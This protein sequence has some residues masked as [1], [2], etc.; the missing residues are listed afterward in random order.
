[1]TRSAC[2]HPLTRPPAGDP[3]VLPGGH[4]LVGHVGVEVEVEHVGEVEFAAG[5]G[6]RRLGGLAPV[7][8][9][10]AVPARAGEEVAVVRVELPGEVPVPALVQRAERPGLVFAFAAFE[11]GDALYARLPQLEQSHRPGVDCGNSSVR[12][13][14][15]VG[16]NR[17]AEM[18][19]KGCNN[20]TYDLIRCSKGSEVV[21]TT[22]SAGDPGTSSTTRTVDAARG[23]GA[24]CEPT[25]R[26]GV[27]HGDQEAQLSRRLGEVEQV[28]DR[29][30][31]RGLRHE[32]RRPRVLL[33]VDHDDLRI[34][35]A[36]S[37]GSY[38]VGRGEGA[39]RRGEAVA[40]R[41][42]ARQA[43]EGVKVP[44]KRVHTH[45]SAGE[46][47]CGDGVEG[48]A[49][50]DDAAAGDAT[51]VAVARGDQ[52][53]H[54]GQRLGQRLGE[55][56]DGL[57]LALQLVGLQPHQ[58]RA[59]PR[60]LGAPKIAGLE[61]GHVLGRAALGNDAQ[62]LLV[63][64]AGVD[65]R[66]VSGRAGHSSTH[67]GVDHLV[68]P[69]LE[70]ALAQ[71]RQQLLALHL[72]AQGREPLQVVV[73]LLR[74]QR[75]VHALG[76][77]EQLRLQRGQLLPVR[78]EDGLGVLALLVGGEREAADALGNAFLAHDDHALQQARGGHVRP[79]ADLNGVGD[80]VDRLAV[81]GHADDPDGLGVDVGEVG[82]DARDLD[83]LLEGQLPDLHLPVG[84]DDLLQP[85]LDAL[86]RLVAQRLGSSDIELELLG[87]QLGPALV[88]VLVVD[89]AEHEVQQVGAGVVAGDLHAAFVV[90]AGLQGGAGARARFRL[91]GVDAEVE[92]H[93]A[94][95]QHLQDIQRAQSPLVPDLA[96]GLGV[97]GGAVQ[98]HDKD[99]PLGEGLV[100]PG[101]GPHGEH[102]DVVLEVRAVAVFDAVAHF[103]RHQLREV[104]GEPEGA[105]EEEGVGAADHQRR[106]AAGCRLQ[107]GHRL[108]KAVAALVQ[109]LQKQHLLVVDRL[110][111]LVVLVLDLGEGEAERGDHAVYQLGQERPRGAQVLP[112]VAH[113]AAQ[114]AAKHVAAPV[115]GGLHA[116]RDGH[117]EAP[118]VV[119]HYAVR[120]VHNRVRS[121]VGRQLRHHLVDVREY[122]G[123]QVAGVVAVARLEHG[124]HA[125]QAHAG[126]DA[127]LGEQLNAA[128]APAVVL[129]EDQ[130]PELH[131]HGVV[132]V[133]QARRVSVANVVVVDFRARAARA[134]VG[135]F[136]EVVLHPE[137][138]DALRRQVAQP[139]LARLLV[140][141]ARGQLGVAAEVGHIEPRLVEL[142]HLGQQLPR[143]V[144]GLLFEVVAEA[145]VAKHLEEGVVVAVAAHVVE[146]VVLAAGADA[147]LAVADALQPSVVGGGVC[148]ARDD[149]LELVHSRVREQQRRIVVREH[150]R[151][152]PEDV[153]LAF[154]V[155]DELAAHPGAAIDLEPGGVD[156]LGGAAG[157]RGGARHLSGTE[158]RRTVL[159]ALYAT[160]CFHYL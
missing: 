127:G 87:V 66:H 144:N 78:R 145:P 112:A 155:A 4:Q 34:L 38:P 123:E 77:L 28:L 85:A 96:A 137:G 50:R 44:A 74:H 82:P 79:A 70:V 15:G 45:T 37:S 101:H 128:I 40:A 110:R 135:H 25:V 47:A 105:V 12:P 58:L 109:R 141:A 125:L 89:L 10:E 17:N 61:L 139:Q 143:V 97:E 20:G 59:R 24:S 138:Q 29:V 118:G 27:A 56:V 129:H 126:I 36:G 147:L 152:L 115:V 76:E 108:F 57:D 72:E 86:Q 93:A 132:G 13:P 107:L 2:A 134:R 46:P 124:G 32:R 148:L 131:H 22:T 90:D 5:N 159:R 62:L 6:R 114:N 18:A 75:G 69:G 120:D 151:A 11:A 153:P 92:D 3:A 119:R 19:S 100:Q 158:G 95:L 160:V 122:V 52:D 35:T 99:L 71:Q 33:E 64:L 49:G 39:R 88:R 14:A 21:T 67:L 73:G 154:E 68:E 26:V 42:G 7:E 23:Q 116:V 54:L 83:G 104:K 81:V 136:P 30:E 31:R 146:V 43:G 142:V 41:R 94:H 102:L 157:R 65:L 1:M 111:D 60:D 9:L 53:G 113:G 63:H 91:R 48:R 140:G 8:Q 156:R 133:D 80:A 51:P 16:I 150:G 121:A 103:A 84:V 98:N 117:R 106:A 130:V 55:E 149:V